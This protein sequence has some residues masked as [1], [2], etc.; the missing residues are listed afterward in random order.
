ME[1]NINEDFI[2]INI[3]NTFIIRSVCKFCKTG[4]TS[5]FTVMNKIKWF[6]PKIAIDK[7]H[8]NK[9]NPKLYP[10]DLPREITKMGCVK[11]YT[12]YKGYNPSR[13]KKKG[14]ASMD[15]LEGLSCKCSRTFWLFSHISNKN[16]MEIVNR[17]GKY[18]YPFSFSD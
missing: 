7:H 17:K 12:D 1:C 13:H 6:N 10:S 9:N 4:P 11:H 2:K 8:R 14:M 16:R 15:F 18:T 5:Y 3:S